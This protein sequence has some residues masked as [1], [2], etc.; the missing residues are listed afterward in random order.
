[1]HI[2]KN[3]LAA[4]AAFLF[5]SGTAVAEKIEINVG[6]VLSEQSSYQK[7][8]VFFAEEMAKR[9]GGN[10]KVNIFS[11]GGLGGE[12]RLVQGGMTGTVDAFVVGQPSLEGVVPEFKILSLP[13][14]FDDET[15]AVDFLN[16]DLGQKMMDLLPK[17]QMIGLGWAGVFTRGVPA[18]KAVDKA[19][20]LSG[21]KVR[22]MQSPGYIATFTAF[23]SQ[24]TPIPFGELFMALQTGV[25]DATDLSPDLVI[26]GQFLKA[27]KFYS[28]TGIHQ[29]PSIFVMSKAK[30]DSLPPDVQKTVIEVGR[31]AAAVS[32]KAQEQL[33]ADGL[34]QMKAAGITI[35][36]PD[37]ASFQEVSRKAWPEIIADVP[38][39][40]DY[41]NLVKSMKGA[42]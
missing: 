11:S 37:V 2:F 23:G 16:R 13:Y 4:T 39:A 27:I 38:N 7:G 35:I 18:N 26:S 1:M 34:E 3:L 10:V 19:S 32:I 41:L 28:R 36:S 29:L 6:H 17:H 5:L 33:M 8:L 14:L 20:D 31:E 30:Y 12:L 42:S 9:T 15:Q 22:V 40:Q 24:S 25:V 21:L